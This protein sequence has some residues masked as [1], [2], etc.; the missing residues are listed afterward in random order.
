MADQQA[1][2]SGPAGN[3]TLKTLVL[4]SASRARQSM[5][6]AAGIVVETD[7]SAIDEGAIRAAIGAEADA[8]DGA[9]LAEIL[10]RAKAEDV[11][12][13]RS[14]AL[15]IAGDQVLVCDGIVHTKPADMDAAR[16]QLLALS[17][18]THQLHSAAVLAEAG[19]VVWTTVS[20]VDVTFRD[21]SPEFVGNYLAAA[22]P[23]ALESVGAYQ[24]E[25]VGAHLISQVRGDHFAV[26]GLPL[27]ELIAALRAHGGV[28]A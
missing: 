20:T 16:K 18:K 28:M 5:L 8:L 19:S 1:M 13:R 7:P 11:S 24:I 10:A 9:D 6:S 25:G 23:V 4:A 27:L 15:V 21:F 17:G 26:L 2:A 12:R 3:L 14:E 22:G